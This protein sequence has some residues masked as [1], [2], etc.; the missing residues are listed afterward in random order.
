MSAYT[1]VARPTADKRLPTTST[2]G[3]SEDFDSGHIQNVKAKPTTIG[4]AESPY[5]QRQL[6]R[7]TANP[8]RRG[9]AANAV[10]VHAVHAPMA[11]VR[12][13]L[14]NA[15]LIIA[16]EPGTKNAAPRPCT[17]RA[18]IRIA[19]A[20]AVAA[21]IDPTPKVTRP[22]RMTGTRPKRSET[23]PPGR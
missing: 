18:A 4:M 23:D 3:F 21:I 20:G 6:S 7:S 15:S 19:G 22:K 11:A 10:P 16:S 14:S 8:P 9:P 12:W 2:R 13:S 1:V 5:T 17:T